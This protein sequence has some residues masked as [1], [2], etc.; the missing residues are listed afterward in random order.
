MFKIN[1][2]NTQASITRRFKSKRIVIERCKMNFLELVG[3]KQKTIYF[4]LT[5]L[6]NFEKEIKRF[7]PTFFEL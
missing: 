7:F 4:H 5:F 3:I 6:L 1:F 2:F